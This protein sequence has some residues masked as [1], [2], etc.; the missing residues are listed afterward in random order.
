MREAAR[1]L[2]EKLAPGTVEVQIAVPALL[3][4]GGELLLLVDELNIR[5]AAKSR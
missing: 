2:K 3:P 5:G 4:F 1:P